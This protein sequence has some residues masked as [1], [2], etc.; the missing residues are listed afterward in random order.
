MDGKKR[1]DRP[2]PKAINNND[3]N[4]YQPK[5]SKP[6]IYNSHKKYRSILPLGNMSV[7]ITLP[8]DWVR[9]HGLTKGDQVRCTE[10]PEGALLV[11]VI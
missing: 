5:R 1:F 4:Y 3:Y 8:A 11:E 9:S 10:T 2:R 7:A 6:M